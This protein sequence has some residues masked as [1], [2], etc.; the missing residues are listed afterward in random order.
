MSEHSTAKP[1]P[2]LY[3]W[4]L[5]ILVAIAVGVGGLFALAQQA[6]I[7]TAVSLAEY[8]KSVI[9]DQQTA[10][11]ALLAEY[12]QVTDDC[13]DA[14][15]C[16][17][18]ATPPSLIPDSDEVSEGVP[19]A[20]GSPGATGSRGE[21]GEQGD[22]GVP[23]QTGPPGPPGAAGA[24]GKPG[25]DGSSGSPG[26]NG[27]TGDPGSSGPAG[28]AGADGAPG[29][30][31]SNGLDGRGIASVVCET[32]GT[33]TIT[34]TDSTTSTTSGPCRIPDPIIIPTPEE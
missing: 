30:P 21:K 23:G 8:R 9:Y 24:D 10:Y 5:V 2:R 14:A 20:P 32:D 27:P 28:P 7:D 17:T 18:T 4:I 29:A 11:D 19:G 12:Q 22:M 31:G 25:A 1:R 6:R 16:V 15:D 3:F 26:S 33:W 34:Y 13:T